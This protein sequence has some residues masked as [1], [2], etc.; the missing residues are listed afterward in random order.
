MTNNII[1]ILLI[2]ILLTIIV[3][4]IL[5]YLDIVEG[6]TGQKE[7]YDVHGQKLEIDTLNN[8]FENNNKT[9]EKYKKKVGEHSKVIGKHLGK[10]VGVH[11]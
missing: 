7:Y 2:I 10:K 8:N 9:F 11:K 1:C 4:N 6:L 3:K 5:A